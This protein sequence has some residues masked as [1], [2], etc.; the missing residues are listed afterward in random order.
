MYLSVTAGPANPV[1]YR[2]IAAV[3]EANRR[4]GRIET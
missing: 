3:P 2:P 4:V 1:K